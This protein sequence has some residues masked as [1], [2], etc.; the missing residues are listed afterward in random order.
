[1]HGTNAEGMVIARL[2]G[3]D[4]EKTVAWL[5]R[6]ETGGLGLL[7][8]S[9]DRRVAYIDRRIE[10]EVLTQARTVGDLKIADFLNALPVSEPEAR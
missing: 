4:S 3:E 1:M 7:W 9:A 5:Y 10:P 6:W 8:T 2:I